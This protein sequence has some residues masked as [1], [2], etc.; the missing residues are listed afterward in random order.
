MRR[1]WM[2]DLGAVRLPAAAQEQENVRTG[3]RR[4]RM[5]KKAVE[6]P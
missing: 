4:D 5:P 3:K 2:S 1:L 6:E